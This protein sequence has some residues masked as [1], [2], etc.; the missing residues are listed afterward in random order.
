MKKLSHF[1]EQGP[2]TWDQGPEAIGSRQPEAAGRLPC[3]ALAKQG[4]RPTPS[5]LRTTD[6]WLLATDSCPGSGAKWKN[7][8]ICRGR[9]QA[10]GNRHPPSPEATAGETGSRH[11]PSPRRASSFARGYGGQDGGRDR[12]QAAGNRQQAIDDR[13][14]EAAGSA[15]PTAAPICVIC[16]LLSVALSEI[17]ETNPNFRGPAND[18]TI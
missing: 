16:G 1:R 18:V 17:C 7:E 13:Q 12:Q 8:I 9:Q 2:G 11:P 5:G 15:R 3:E 10:A 6:Y 14:P 4:A